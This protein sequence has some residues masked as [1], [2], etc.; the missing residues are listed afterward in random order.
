MQRYLNRYRHYLTIQNGTIVLAAIIALGW[1]WGTVQTLQKNFTYQQ[2]VDALAETV[3]LEKL[4]N[5]NLEFQQQ[6]YRSDEFLELSA[7]QRLGKAN[8][9]E[10]LIILPDSRGIVDKQTATGNTP[11]AV[12]ASNLSQWVQFFFGNKAD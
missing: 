1:V 8:P 3:E 6:Y 12:K 4:R 5:E 11:A 9:G 7:R 10:K 2:Q